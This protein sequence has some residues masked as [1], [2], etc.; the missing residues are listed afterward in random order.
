MYSSRQCYELGI[1][2]ILQIKKLK[3]RE[4]RYFAH[5]H[6][7]RLVADKG[8]KFRLTGQLSNIASKISNCEHKT[9]QKKLHVGNENKALFPIC[10]TLKRRV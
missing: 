6:M 1:I 7:A 2:C 9:V 4:A 3:S 10:S 8:L 5:S